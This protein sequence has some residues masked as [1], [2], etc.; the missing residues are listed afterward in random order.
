MKCLVLLKN[1]GRP[2]FRSLLSLSSDNSLQYLQK[3]R[4]SSQAVSISNTQFNIYQSKITGNAS[5]LRTYSSTAPDRPNESKLHNEIIQQKLKEQ[6][7]GEGMWK[8]V[9]EGL[10]STQVKLV[11]SFSL[12]TSIIGLSIQPFIINHLGSSMSLVVSF[13][14][15][16][17]MFTFVTPALIHWF[18]KK[19]VFKLRYD[20]DTDLYAATTLSFFLREKTIH[21]RPAD[22]VI[23]EIPRM[24]TTF[25][26]KKKPLFVDM[27]TFKDIEHFGRI[28]GYDKPLDLR[29][30]NRDVKK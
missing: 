5:Y 20:P 3:S 4:F 18:T 29:V 11:K 27:E 8:E 24:F 28:M 15:L 1:I 22:V 17:G 30:E 9:Y 6:A 14:A 16:I 7:E 12:G 10:L 26:V 21:F 23:P 25:V 13:S 2:S 19:Y